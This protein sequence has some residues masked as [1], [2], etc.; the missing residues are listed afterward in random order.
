MNGVTA[1]YGSS[2][3]AGGVS[4]GT[5]GVTAMILGYKQNSYFN[6]N[7][8]AKKTYFAF[9]NEIICIGSGINQSTY[10]DDVYTTVEN[11]LVRNGDVFK[12]DGQTATSGSKNA[13]YAHF[14]NMGGYVFDGQ[15]TV[16]YG[17]NGSFLEITLSHGV[18]PTDG[19]YFFIY[20]PTATE[21]ETKAYSD[22]MSARIEVI[23]R[24]GSVH[25]VKDKDLG[26]TAYAF[27][28]AGSCNGVTVSAPCTLMISGGKLFVSDPTQTLTSLTVT[29]NGTNYLF[30]LT[31]NVGGTYEKALS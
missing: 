17:F 14:T 5:Y 3:F 29:V 21:A 13:R 27:Y 18:R 6:T 23:S 26:I 1:I 7:L 16:T 2:D 12:V 9:D 25:A 20:L 15:Q 28:E 8:T 30:D 24:S 4:D 31:G 10:G 11:R 22:N 19:E